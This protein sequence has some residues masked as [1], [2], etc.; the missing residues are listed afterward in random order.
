MDYTL[1]EYD[2]NAWEGKA[3]QYG[4]HTLMEMG[5]PVEGLKFD[6]ELVIRC[7]ACGCV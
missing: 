3:Y 5:F 1:I 4:L 7:G 6:P 2:V